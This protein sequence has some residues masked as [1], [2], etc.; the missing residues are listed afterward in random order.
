[1]VPEGPDVS[2]PD[3]SNLNTVKEFRFLCITKL[4]YKKVDAYLIQPGRQKQ[5]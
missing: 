5:T 3:K 2:S 4:D 1:M